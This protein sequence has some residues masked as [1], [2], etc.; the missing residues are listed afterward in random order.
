MRILVVD[1]DPDLLRGLVAILNAPGTH[2]VRAAVNGAKALEHAAASGGIDLL[3]TDV[4]MEP[5]DGFSL[6]QQLEQQFGAVRTIFV[7]G[8]DLSDYA[9]QTAGCQVLEKPVD[10]A[11]LWAAIEAAFSD[12]EEPQF[13]PAKP[14]ATIEVSRSA[15]PDPTT[16][17]SFVEPAARR[18]SD[19]RAASSSI[20]RDAGG[21]AVGAQDVERSSRPPAE[22]GATAHRQMPV[23]E[24]PRPAAVGWRDAR[25]P[26]KVSGPSLAGQT[27]GNYQV[28]RDLGRSRWGRVYAALQVSM[29]RPV[30]LKVL[31]AE[32]RNDATATARFIADARAKAHVQHPSILSV[33]E[34]GEANDHIY[35]AHEFVQGRTVREIRI[36]GDKIAESVGLKTLG[37]VAEGL[38]YLDARN[39]PHTP[40]DETSIFL[41]DDGNPRLA[42]I[43]TQHADQPSIPLAD[44]QTLGRAVLSILPA[45]QTIS[46]G[47]RMLL[48]RMVQSGP[49][50]VVSW[51]AVLQEVKSLAPKIVP[52]EAA[53][54]TAQERAAIDALETARRQQKR[55]FWLTMATM[56]GTLATLLFVVWYF[57]VRTNER[58]LDVQVRIPA[59]EYLIGKG[60][61]VSL[62]E[63]WIDKYEVTI[64]QYA[65]FLRYLEAH[66]TADSEFN[67]PRQPPHLQHEPADWRIYYGRAQAGKP[68]HGVPTSLNSPMIM[69]TWWDAYAYAKWKGRELPTEEQW[70]A[71]GRGKE[72]YV[73]PWGNE[74]DPKRV[75]SNA[76]FNAANPAALGGVD[77]FNF[78]GDVDA[79]NGDRSPFGVFGLAGNVSEW[80]GAWSPEQRPIVKGGNFMSADV[81]LD[82]RVT[83][84]DPNKGEEYIGFRTI[85]KTPPK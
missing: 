72:G 37:V 74:P 76:D 54:I 50:A 20:E 62:E 21:R 64:G 6:R 42:N 65:A 81:R 59:G 4:V 8:Y 40:L 79:M 84:R 80:I 9:A 17:G 2:E 28:L 55:S 58:K 12:V 70:E 30:A 24:P 19:S 3:I 13:A 5:I 16:P 57:L 49:D 25:P 82:R 61:R 1:D 7:T 10:S 14:S 27:L 48:S 41:T 75:N 77:G 73:Y 36:S 31:D 33:Y 29:N 39:I 56:I 11:M 18:S 53:R 67:H 83:D 46:V 32:H 51:N 66:P 85:S 45:I 23:W 60:Q 52:V 38:A 26:E 44:I 34:A 15:P 63:F 68:V 69:C 47:L 43:A 22:N 78:W 35:Y 71:A